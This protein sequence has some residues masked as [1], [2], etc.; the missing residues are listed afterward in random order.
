MQH[1]VVRQ[2]REKEE[3]VCICP[4]SLASYLCF[5]W[6]GGPGEASW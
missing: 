4:L 5:F 3:L 1:D 2:I 6:G